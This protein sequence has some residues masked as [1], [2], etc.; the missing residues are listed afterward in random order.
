MNLKT[1]KA[2]ILTTILLDVAISA[3]FLAQS[4]QFLMFAALPAPIPVI[5]VGVLTL[6]KMMSASRMAA[7]ISVEK[8]RFLKEEKTK[9]KVNN[10]VKMILSE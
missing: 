6:I 5:L 9:I 10:T 7:S 3:I 4:S 2:P 8:K 1:A